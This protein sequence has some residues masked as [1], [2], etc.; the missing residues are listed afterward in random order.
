[1]T[2]GQGRT[3]DF[4][5][6]V[7]IMTSNVG[8]DA[9][10]RSPLGFSTPELDEN[11]IASHEYSKQLKRMFRPEFLNRIDE[12]VVFDALNKSNVPAIVRILMQEIVTR[13][14]E[15]GIGVELTDA[16]AAHLAE[17]GFNPEYGARPLRRL[18]QRQVETELSKRML[19]GD[20]QTG[21][22]VVIDFGPGAEGTD[23]LLFTR[24]D[25]E[26][27]AVEWSTSETTP[28]NSDGQVLA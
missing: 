16:A 14:D 4:R 8:A 5:N 23:E 28:A 12:T 7:I 21:D 10:K 2:D 19:R 20:Y 17:I 1:M 22:L 27:I 6:T 15:M 25:P 9:I 24:Q 13:M 3:V 26:P 11:A 18:L